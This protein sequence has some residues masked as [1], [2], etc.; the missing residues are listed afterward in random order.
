MRMDGGGEGVRPGQK[1]FSFFRE[2]QHFFFLIL[3]L[4]GITNSM[5]G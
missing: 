3:G 5:Y 1:V 4:I 2:A